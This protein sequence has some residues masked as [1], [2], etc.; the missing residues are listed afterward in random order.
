MNRFSSRNAYLFSVSLLFI[1]DNVEA[2]FFSLR[3]FSFFFS[4]TGCTKMVHIA[5]ATRCR[6]KKKKKNTRRMLRLERALAHPKEIE[7][8]LPVYTNKVNLYGI[9]HRQQCCFFVLQMLSESEKK[10]RMKQSFFFFFR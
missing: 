8:K 7:D 10:M 5:H 3:S 6:E 1:L 4:L 2:C 9:E